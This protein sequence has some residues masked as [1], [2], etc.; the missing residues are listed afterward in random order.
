MQRPL[1]PGPLL[2]AGATTRWFAERGVLARWPTED[3]ACQEGVIGPGYEPALFCEIG[4]T[5]TIGTPLRGWA[6]RRVSRLRVRVVRD[7][8]TVLL[9]D[10]PI[11]FGTFGEEEERRDDFALAVTIEPGATLSLQELAPRACARAREAIVKIED[12]ALRDLELRLVERVCAARG[13]YA[14]EGAGLVRALV[15]P[16]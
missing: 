16:R 12:A 2:G 3:E 7:A 6:R 9:L 5:E 14:L 8:A 13:H 4:S 11:A 15:K 1:L 10:V